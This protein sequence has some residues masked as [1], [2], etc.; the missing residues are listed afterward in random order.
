M[1]PEEHDGERGRR[2]QK[3]KAKSEDVDEMEA[4]VEEE[5]AKREDETTVG[6]RVKRRQRERKRDTERRSPKDP[7]TETRTGSFLP[8]PFCLLLLAPETLLPFTQGKRHSRR[9]NKKK[10][11]RVERERE[12]RSRERRSN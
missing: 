5:D 4:R 10:E 6:L 11:R 7:H 9:K 8:P 1:L 3:R 12:R 2:V